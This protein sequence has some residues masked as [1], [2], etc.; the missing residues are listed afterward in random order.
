M[1]GAARG[2]ARWPRQCKRV[3]EKRG[4]E[5]RGVR[6]LRY[7][8]PCALERSW[9]RVVLVGHAT[10]C[11]HW[12][13]ETGEEHA[14]GLQRQS[15]DPKTSPGAIVRKDMGMRREGVTFKGNTEATTNLIEKVTLAG[16]RW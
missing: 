4:E 10:S 15:R 14:P 8:V 2:T 6:H 11:C 13:D 12:R 7:D 5:R 1:R 3:E 16:F 9:L